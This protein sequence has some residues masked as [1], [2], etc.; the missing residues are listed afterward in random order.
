MG[1]TNSVHLLQCKEASI[2]LDNAQIYYPGDKVP[3]TL[4]L[5]HKDAQHALVLTFNR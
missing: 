2:A 1:S 4:H 5:K 3:V